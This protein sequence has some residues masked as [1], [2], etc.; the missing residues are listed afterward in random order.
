VNIDSKIFVSS[1]FLQVVVVIYKGIIS[2]LIRF[3]DHDLSLVSINNH[4]HIT[5]KSLRI[6]SW[7]SRSWGLIGIRTISSA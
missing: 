5:V 4:T 2:D 6:L 3:N 7:F 1:H